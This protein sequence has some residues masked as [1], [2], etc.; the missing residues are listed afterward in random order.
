MVHIE[1]EQVVEICFER[2]KKSFSSL[3]PVTLV[4]L[5]L[6]LWFVKI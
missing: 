3:R 5:K 1:M 4:K 2:R 6:K